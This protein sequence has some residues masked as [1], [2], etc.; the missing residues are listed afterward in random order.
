MADPEP[1]TDPIGAAPSPDAGVSRYCL[2]SRRRDLLAAV[3]ATLLVLA[4]SPFLRVYHRITLVDVSVV[5]IEPD[6][7]R[8]PMPTPS[9][10]WNRGARSLV[11]QRSV[12]AAVRAADLRIQQVMRSDPAIAAAPP[13]TRFEWVIRYSENSARLDRSAVHVYPAPADAPR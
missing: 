9:S 2:G 6:G 11:A 12:R 13:G 10:L 4:G 1:A 5:R 3:V 8:I 7:R